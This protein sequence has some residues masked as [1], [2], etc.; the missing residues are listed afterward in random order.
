MTIH[1]MTD[2]FAWGAVISIGFLLLATIALIAIK[3]FV[4]QIHSRLLGV[5]EKE[6]PVLY[7]QYLANFKIV[8]LVFFVIPYLSLKIIGE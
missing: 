3:D 8:S 6:L 2:F 1:Q 7:F 5:P 4:V